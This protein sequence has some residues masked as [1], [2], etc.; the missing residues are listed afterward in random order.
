VPPLPTVADVEPGVEPDVRTIA[1][2][3]S[4]YQ[5]GSLGRII[6]T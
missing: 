6:G 1:A 4:E 2:V 3:G 5:P